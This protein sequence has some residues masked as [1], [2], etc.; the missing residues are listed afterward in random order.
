M[1]SRN[2]RRLEL[3]AWAEGEILLG[4]GFAKV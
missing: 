3:V 4:F 1:R 2:R